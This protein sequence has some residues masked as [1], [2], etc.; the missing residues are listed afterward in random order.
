[1]TMTAAGTVTDGNTGSNYTYTFVTSNTGTITARTLTVT[2]A[3][4][5]KTYDANTTAAGVPTITS[6]ALQGTD[7]PG[8]TETYNTKNVGTGKALNPGGVA[9][10]GNSGN[11]YTYNFVANLT[12]VITVRALTVTAVTNSKLYDGSASAAGVPTIT[13]GVLQGSDTAGFTES[14]N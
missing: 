4:N 1:K 6:G 3:T 5:S 13:S 9:N 12:G 2:A 7:T 14:Y 8:F 10:D 11:N